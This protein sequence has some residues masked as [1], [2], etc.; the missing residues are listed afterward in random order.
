MPER[1]AAVVGG[2]EVLSPGGPARIRH[3][4]VGSRAETAEAERDRIGSFLRASA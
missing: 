2:R 1:E 4:A 3:D